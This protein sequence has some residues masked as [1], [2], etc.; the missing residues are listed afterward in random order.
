MGFYFSVASED[1]GSIWPTN[2]FQEKRSEEE[3]TFSGSSEKLALPDQANE[4]GWPAEEETQQQFLT[5]SQ[6]Q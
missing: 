2:R 1:E 4:Q 5:E 6:A 3:F